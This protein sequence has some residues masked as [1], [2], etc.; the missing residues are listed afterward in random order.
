MSYH[1]GD[2]A[3]AHAIAGKRARD[4]NPIVHDA[5]TAAVVVSSI[6]FPPAFFAVGAAYVGTELYKHKR[7]KHENNV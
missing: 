3:G 4:R 7:K 2:Y 5:W 1:R 6:I